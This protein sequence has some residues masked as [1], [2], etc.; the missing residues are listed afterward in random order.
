MSR[1]YAR[2][3]CL[4]SCRLY[5]CCRECFA[6]KKSKQPVTLEETQRFARASLLC[7]AVFIFFWLLLFGVWLLWKL[8][9]LSPVD[10][11]NATGRFT[12]Q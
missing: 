10:N 5:L 1:R 4:A 6:G 12:Q 8:L 9:L 7:F 3:P 11:G 2:C